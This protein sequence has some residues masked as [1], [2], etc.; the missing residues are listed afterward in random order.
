MTNTSCTQL[1][2]LEKVGFRFPECFGQSRHPFLDEKGHPRDPRTIGFGPCTI[3][4][5][6]EALCLESGRFRII[7]LS[8]DGCGIPETADWAESL[9]NVDVDA[10]E[11]HG[12][13]LLCMTGQEWKQMCA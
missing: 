1:A 8:G 12:Y 13:D 5:G 9:I 6:T 11:P 4:G 7:V 2:E 10:N 3:G